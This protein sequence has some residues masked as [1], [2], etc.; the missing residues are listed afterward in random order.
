MDEQFPSVERSTKRDRPPRSTLIPTHLRATRR[1]WVF[2]VVVAVTGFAIVEGARALVQSR[3]AVAPGV[4][5]DL[6]L[7][8]MAPL[9][10]DARAAGAALGDRI[11]AVDGQRFDDPYAL[12]RAMGSIGVD[13]EIS[14]EV[15]SD[16]NVTRTVRLATFAPSMPT[17]WLRFSVALAFA[18]IGIAVFWFHPG[19]RESW[20]FLFGCAAWAVSGLAGL[21]APRTVQTALDSRLGLLAHA[22]IGPMFL[23]LIAV[24]PRPVRVVVR[25]PQLLVVLDVF[26]VALGLL[27]WA[28]QPTS[29][30]L[31]L[32]MFAT[33]GVNALSITTVIAILVW[34]LRRPAPREDLTRLRA[35]IVAVVLAFP[36][37]AGLAVAYGLGL[38]PTLPLR[39][40]GNV[41]ALWFPLIVG[42]ATLRR[43]LF[44]ID[45]TIARTAAASAIVGAVAIVMTGVAFAIPQ[46]VAP[47]SV[48]GSPTAMTLVVLGG[49]A[50]LWP[51]KLRVQ[52]R[53]IDRFGRPDVDERLQVVREALV[54]LAASADP[55]LF[56]RFERRL[57]ELVD[58][59]DAALLVTD[60][61]GWRRPATG[62]R[63]AR[64]ALPCLVELRLGDEVIGALGFGRPD[65]RFALLPRTARLVD[66]LVPEIAR[67]LRS[68]HSGEKIGD[69][70][71]DRFLAAGGMGNV[72]VGAKIGAGGFVKAVAIK[73]LLPELAVDPAA[74]QRFLKEARLVARL[75][76]PG[77]VQTLE[78]GETDRGYFIVMEYVQ[79]VDVATL[80]RQLKRRRERIP[81]PL[82]AH[83]VTSAC[84]ALDHVHRA[85]DEGG[86]PLK[87]I[88]H[89]VSPQ[90]L[91]LDNEG[92]VKL[93]DFGVAHMRHD[94]SQ[95]GQLVGK[96][97]YISPEQ[98]AGV[99]Y[100]HRIDVF[101]AGV[102]LYELITGQHPFVRGTEEATLR[103]TA[104]GRYL[105]P[106]T[107]REDC[108]D[109]L[110][111]VI[112]R[113]VA[114]VDARYAS[115]AE[116]AEALQ[117]IYP[118]DTRQTSEL[119][120]LVRC[121]QEADSKV[122]S[123]VV[124]PTKTLPAR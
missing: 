13:R 16:E 103:A 19:R 11:V 67:A 43:D 59:A 37:P 22:L 31:R 99:E 30:P 113:A 104:Q 118:L 46:L 122:S 2:L 40:I 48:L 76:H 44:E 65:T 4:Y 68:R 56:S 114:P 86:A 95:V 35:L 121:A 32:A 55:A 21:G 89:D 78:L 42:Y 6:K 77:I 50:V 115:A 109:A 20:P 66:L 17:A 112:A 93:A 81:L 75:S 73:L 49:V 72:Y 111:H 24:F 15:A 62:E 90:N 102:V 101:A 106:E 3:R 36:V 63:V 10:D 26:A 79:G 61:A 71:I 7:H 45:R 8:I 97:G 96:V 51:I 117:D 110:V 25:R 124:V 1:S 100:D 80:L 98:I 94:A 12:H 41:M 88:H 58:V 123:G 33:A 116:L 105:P 5:Y 47:D 28:L 82:A 9:P 29:G 64:D 108:P 60:D 119:G 38:E 85:C 39:W 84:V 83:I 107:I 52:R 70:R 57:E 92:N 91:M 120:R 14:L 53:L 54:D 18:L 87:L 34:R 27:L 74:V 23:H 69:Y